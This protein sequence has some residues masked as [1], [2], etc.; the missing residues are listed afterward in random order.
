MANAGV[1]GGGG[2]GGGESSS[3]SF[4]GSSSGGAGVVYYFRSSVKPISYNNKIRMN[5]NGT[6][7]IPCFFEGPNS[8]GN[9]SYYSRIYL[10]RPNGIVTPNHQTNRT[11]NLG[12]NAKIYQ[13]N[14]GTS[15]T[16][17]EIT[18]M[19][20]YQGVLSH[21]S[22][23]A[24]KNGTKLNL[25][26]F[27]DNTPSTK[28]VTSS[29]DYGEITSSTTKSL[30]Y[31]CGV[32][33][34]N[35]WYFVL[36]AGGG[37]GGGADNSWGLFNY[38]AGGGGGGGGGAAGFM[39]RVPSGASWNAVI[40]VGG[41][42]DGGSSGNGSRPAGSAGGD[43][44]VQIK[45]ASGTVVVDFTVG[46]GKGGGGANGDSAG[47]G[48]AGGQCTA[49]SSLSD[50][51]YLFCFIVD[52]GAGGSVGQG[53][54]VTHS[55]FWNSHTTPAINPHT[56][57][58]HKVAQIDNAGGYTGSQNDRGGGGGLSYMGSGGYY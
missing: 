43:T 8:Y 31:S 36:Q 28:Y 14:S 44:R 25:L 26:Y 10:S 37:G 50:P 55:S 49:S 33:G 30:Q 11:Y 16:Y 3:D 4:T 17:T 47:G 6:L 51:D 18:D 29:W 27:S 42:G 1:R 58:P 48:G 54:G 52:G 2:A 12:S 13:A 40:T 53:G 21:A 38:A 45:N 39:V 46:G 15:G 20:G 24:D 41:G 32:N 22:K 56:F 23:I 5:V 19:T 57:N 35:Y 7:Y 9:Y 34:Y